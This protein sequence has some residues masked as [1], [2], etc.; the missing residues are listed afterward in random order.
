MIFLI[1]EIFRIE[2]ICM[3]SKTIVFTMFVVFSILSGLSIYTTH[4]NVDDAFGEIHFQEL[5]FCNG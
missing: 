1:L 4:Q 5:T 3:N 2:L